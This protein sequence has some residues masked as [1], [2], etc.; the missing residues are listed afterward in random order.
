MSTITH[1]DPQ[2]IYT[3]GVIHCEGCGKQTR[4]DI[5]EEYWRCFKETDE[6]GDEPNGYIWI[7][8]VCEEKL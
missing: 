8:P 5:A 7:C 6:P 1:P 3:G 2:P 4:E